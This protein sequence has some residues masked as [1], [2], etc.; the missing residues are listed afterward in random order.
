MTMIS[1]LIRT[2]A[3]TV[4]ATVVAVCAVP[5]AA[6]DFDQV[7]Q[8]MLNVG[9]VD[10]TSPRDVNRVIAQLRHL[11]LDMCTVDGNA[12]ELMNS[13]AH[14][15]Y[16]TAIKNGMDQIHVR[17]QMAAAGAGVHVAQGPAATV[18]QK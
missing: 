8:G 2:G 14:T 6:T 17:E 1:K 16:N 3:V 5:A 18:Q 13:D 4:A 10:F 11:A 7:P 12:R 15:C 9:R